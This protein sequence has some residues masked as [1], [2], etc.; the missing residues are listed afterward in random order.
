[1]DSRKGSGVMV[2]GNMKMLLELVSGRWLER[3]ERR[4]GK[5]P[6]TTDY[7]G[8]PPP[9]AKLGEDFR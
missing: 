9:R 3:S 8:G 6:S 2:G 5:Y 1:M 4:R 7:V